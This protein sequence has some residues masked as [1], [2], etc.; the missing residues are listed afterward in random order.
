[1]RNVSL[2]IVLIVNAVVA[3]TAISGSRA[4][5]NFGVF[6]TLPPPAFYISFPTANDIGVADPSTGEI[7][8]VISVFGSPTA[9]LAN[10]IR[11]LV[12]IVLND[13][14]IYAIQTFSQL[15]RGEVSFGTICSDYAINSAGSKIYAACG[16]SIEIVDTK[17][18]TVVGDIQ[19]PSVVSGLAISNPRHQ[20]FAGLPNIHSF[21]TIDVDN[22]EIQ[23]VKY[24]GECAI[25]KCAPDDLNVSPDDRY[26]ID[27]E[28]LHCQ[29]KIYDVETLS[30]VSKSPVR[31]ENHCA[32][33]GVDGYDNELW[34][35]GG[36]ALGNIVGLSLSPPFGQTGPFVESAMVRSAAFS[37]SGQ[38]FAVGRRFK[39][40]DPFVLQP[41]PSFSR[42]VTL[43]SDP[44]EIVYVP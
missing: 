18:F 14:Q 12:Y 1:M 20:L 28:R 15:F 2:V 41:F 40:R 6:E 29:A 31:G 19:L 23:R 43:W 26:L 34:I 4:A 35:D 7:E 8:G 9:I 44:S 22:D 17:T 10:P 3:L 5:A 33:I 37:P 25:S 11:P 13:Q 16:Q 42:T 30:I 24:V 38:G 21:A 32:S 27:I 36:N 39:F